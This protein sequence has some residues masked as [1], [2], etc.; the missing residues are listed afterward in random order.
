MDE[1]SSRIA[2]KWCVCKNLWVKKRT[3]RKEYEKNLKLRKEK[4]FKM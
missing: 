1:Y 3:A 4:F 2:F